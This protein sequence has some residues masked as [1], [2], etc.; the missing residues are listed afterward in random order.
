M[1]AAACI[2][3]ITP[4]ASPAGDG[5]LAEPSGSS[6]KMEGV[7]PPRGSEVMYDSDVEETEPPSKQQ[8]VDHMSQLRQEASDDEVECLGC[9]GSNP[10]IDF[11]HARFHCRA[12]PIASGTEHK[13]CANC[14]CCICDVPASEC[15]NWKDDHCKADPMDPETKR[16]KNVLNARASLN[17]SDLRDLRL[18]ELRQVFPHERDTKVYGTS[19]HAAQRQ[20]VA[21]MIRNETEGIPTHILFTPRASEK[22]LPNRFYG[23]ILAAEMGMGKTL[24]VIALYLERPMKTLVIAPQLPTVQWQDQFAKYAPHVKVRAL[25]CECQSKIEAEIHRCDVVIVNYTSG[26]IESLKQRIKRV[27]VDESHMV[28]NG[29]KS[30]GATQLLN[31][32][33]DYNV[34]HVWL[35]SGT[36][37]AS[38][39]LTS[40]ITMK[41][42]RTLLQ[43]PSN[44]HDFDLTATSVDALKYLIMR[45]ETKQQLKQADG[46]SIEVLPMPKLNIET[47][48][49]DLSSEERE[50]YELAACIDGWKDPV[51]ISDTIDIISHLTSRFELRQYVLGE[52]IGKFQQEV[53]KHMDTDM[54]AA[55]SLSPHE[56]RCIVDRIIYRINEICRHLKD[57]NS[58][59][60]AV[61][62]EIRMHRESNPSFKAIIVSNSFG[63]GAYI[64]STKYKV[65]VMQRQ[66]GR[67]SVADQR[68]LLDFQQGNFDILVCSFEAVRIG[69]NLE[70]AG[71]IYF[72]DTSIDETEYQQA[73][74]R[75]AR[76][77]TKHVKLT[78]TFV[79][80]RNTIS[81]DIF[82]YHA[83]RRAGKSVAEAAKRF[84]NDDVHEF[85]EPRDVYRIQMGEVSSSFKFVAQQVPDQS[86]TQLF[87]SDMD[88]DEAFEI[89]C[90]DGKK[91]SNEFDVT[92]TIGTLPAYYDTATAVIVKSKT[93]EWSCR[94]DIP[95]ATTRKLHARVTARDN[96]DW[97]NTDCSKWHPARA[98]SPVTI[99]L[100]R[101]DGRLFPIHDCIYALK[102]SC[103]CC[104]WCGWRVIHSSETR[105]IGSHERYTVIQDG[106]QATLDESTKLNSVM[107][108]LRV[109]MRDVSDSCVRSTFQVAFT[110]DN[111]E[112]SEFV[113]KA[114]TYAHDMGVV[115]CEL[116]YKVMGDQ[117]FD[118]QKRYAKVMVKLSGANR[119][120]T[121]TFEHNG[122]KYEAFV[123]EL[124]PY[125]DNWY[126]TAYVLVDAKPTST[127]II[128]SHS[129]IRTRLTTSSAS[130][131]SSDGRLTLR[132]L[133]KRVRND[134]EKKERVQALLRDSQLTDDER[135]QKI[136]EIL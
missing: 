118:K 72:V 104:R 10:L 33:R 136:Q 60:D 117:Y 126:A 20:M 31:N 111:A 37:F 48:Q 130:S 7:P 133:C 102:A 38:G 3:L 53:E 50:L 89:M 103:S 81:E 74:A 128:E 135:I 18:Q 76:C 25:Y 57:K 87:M 15:P 46:R 13:A 122:C 22:P 80:I 16:R 95:N 17:S 19:L 79:Y 100:L 131:S 34:Q 55:D 64:K 127:L 61:L 86:L 49:V 1:S 51:K 43:K 30:G 6:V 84:E 109:V 27:V 41:H 26:L 63:A 9:S 23:G 47:L 132:E 24:T 83:E 39:N 56:F 44:T 70:Q 35:V 67:S 69:I 116:K 65:G 21:W 77:G 96:T 106:R 78:A 52:Q 129:I 123:K 2:N 93:S 88:I 66:K 5:E 98:S 82:N 134:P 85:C 108:Q 107:G 11:A 14:Y 58:K 105:C 114:K 12:F 92:L 90:G 99:R 59:I 42:F 45:M 62:D 75:I 73:C 29:K 110:P 101:S 120:D 4:P 71:H 32:L 40:S 91:D 94:F 68:T 97:F 119:G 124:M 112:F 115:P 36:P 54:Y 113:Q 8:R 121:I 28:L 125:D